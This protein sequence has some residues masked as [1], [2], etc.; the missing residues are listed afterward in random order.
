MY[1]ILS[2][3]NIMKYMGSSRMLCEKLYIVSW[4]WKPEGHNIQRHF[5]N[6]KGD[7]PV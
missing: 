1:S 2:V 7:I 4:N 3:S 6:Q 5:E